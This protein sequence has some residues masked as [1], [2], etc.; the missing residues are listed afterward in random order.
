MKPMAPATRAAGNSSRM[1]PK[2]SGKMAPATPWM[3]R[4]TRITPR[5]VPSA[6][7][8]VPTLRA[9][10]TAT[11][12]FSLPRVSP[13]R[14]STGVAMAAL[15]QVGGQQPAGAGLGGVQRV[16]ELGDGRDDQR[17]QEAEGQGGGGQHGEGDAV[18]GASLA[19]SCF[20]A[21]AE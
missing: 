19:H 3:I 11:M 9:M 20:L 6:L 8:S 1:M 13:T 21:E 15:E 18:V 14:P 12:T 10:S 5:L 7:I 17:L 2:A 4:P 16:L